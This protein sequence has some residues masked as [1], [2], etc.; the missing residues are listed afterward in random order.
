MHSKRIVLVEGVRTPIGRYGDVIK[1]VKSGFLASRV[2]EGVL[3]KSCLSPTYVD[4]VILGEVR[5]TSESSNVARVAALR[6][7]IPHS[8]SAFTVNRLCAS[9]M[10]A[11][12]SGVQQIQ[13]GQAKKVIAGGTESMSN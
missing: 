7:G 6:A 11:I 3:E 8:A 5:Q 12:A 13:S 9:V 10:Q 2:I 1:N 4:E